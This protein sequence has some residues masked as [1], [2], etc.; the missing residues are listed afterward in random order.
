MTHKFTF[1]V[2]V[3]MCAT[4]FPSKHPTKH[5][6]LINFFKSLKYF[7]TYK[8]NICIFRNKTV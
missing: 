1:D 7:Q 8:L 6:F 5:V 2:A 3:Q 4:K